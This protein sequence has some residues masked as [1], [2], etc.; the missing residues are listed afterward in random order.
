MSSMFSSMISTFLAHTIHLPL[1]VVHLVLHLALHDF[2]LDLV[3]RH[4]GV[5]FQLRNDLVRQR[6]NGEFIL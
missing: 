6:Q 4:K 2:D 5:T 3:T 1:V